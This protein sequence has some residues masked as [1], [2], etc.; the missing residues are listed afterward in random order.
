MAL[1]ARDL[2]EFCRTLQTGLLAL[3]CSCVLFFSEASCSIVPLSQCLV[4]RNQFINQLSNH[5]SY[6]L[7]SCRSVLLQIDVM[8]RA[9]AMCDRGSLRAAHDMLF[10]GAG[11]GSKGS[12]LDLKVANHIFPTI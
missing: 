8:T 11:L 2:V 5:R 10:I 9:I 6:L 7:L 12:T 4:S 1:H 3:L